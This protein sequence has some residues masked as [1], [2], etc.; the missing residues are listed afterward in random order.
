MRIVRAHGIGFCYGVRRAIEL[1]VRR[2][3]R[4][5]IRSL[6]PLIHNR[7]EVSRLENLGIRVADSIE[8]CAHETVIIRSHGATAEDIARARALDIS[9]VDATCPHVTR[10]KEIVLSLQ[11]EGREVLL[12][13]DRRHP[14]VQAI[15]SFAAAGLEVIRGP[16]DIE[17]LHP[18][19]PL[20]LVAQTTQERKAFAALAAEVR[21]RFPD[22]DIRDT[23]CQD[24]ARRQEEASRLAAEVGLVLVVGGRESAN[25]SRLTQICRRLQ[26]RTI[27]IEQAAELS[28]SILSGVESVGLI[29]G[30]STP[31]WV[32]QEVERR[33]MGL[34]P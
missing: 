29:S 3:E 20:G 24:A 25:T 1:A 7:Q 5:P 19:R 2:A 10:C 16:E 12:H 32:I 21:R 28:P 30:A 9:L 26:P 8:S 22:A 15:L 33:L 34:E 17:A 18:A 13:G 27:Q 23:I 31:D 6:G 4:G 11:Q 14:E